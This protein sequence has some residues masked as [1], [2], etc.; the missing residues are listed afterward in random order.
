MTNSHT[1]FH[2]QLDN[3]YFPNWIIITI[4][5]LI[6]AGLQILGSFS[7]LF[8]L[9][10]YLPIGSSSIVTATIRVILM[11]MSLGWIIY[12][13]YQKN[14]FPFEK[15]SIS[16]L[17]IL[18][19]LAMRFIYDAYIGH[20][21]Y[22]E[23]F[24]RSVVRF[25]LYFGFLV[26][27]TIFLVNG[28][29]RS[30]GKKIILYICIL[31]FITTVGLYFFWGYYFCQGITI[32][33][34]VTSYPTIEKYVIL[35]EKMGNDNYFNSFLSA[36]HALETISYA[37]SI[38]FWA[39][40]NKTISIKVFLPL[41]IFFLLPCYASSTRSTL[42]M[43]I[44]SHCLAAVF[45]SYKNSFTFW[46][47]ILLVIVCHLICLF[48]FMG[49]KDTNRT[50]TILGRWTQVVSM[51]SDATILNNN[52]KEIENKKTKIEDK[53]VEI[54][55]KEVEI[56]DK[57]TKIKNDSELSIKINSDTYLIIKNIRF[58][59]WK[60]CLE[61]IYK[62]PI[63]GDGLYIV[64]NLLNRKKDK[65]WNTHPHNVVIQVFMGLG[66]FG[67]TLFLFILG[68]G[69]LDAITCL[70]VTPEMGWLSILFFMVIIRSLLWTDIVRDY[71][72]WFLLI[73]LRAN[74][75]HLYSARHK[76]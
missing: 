48:I 23:S 26:L 15:F 21:I 54:K 38:I 27:P 31:S 19:L 72:L 64:D 8:V 1:L 12:F 39:S 14:Y 20:F 68:R 56:K 55:D 13:I 63:T 75:V 28:I 66:I 36:I 52:D 16:I 24:S 50:M 34:M 3:K 37:V 5:T 49:N 7:S 9:E 10:G 69:I 30:N 22:P 76:K 35:K 51:R 2:D 42:L 61:R 62:S 70:Y 65:N 67:G 53:E 45:S 58:F 18:I 47:K 33:S 74:T 57:E 11:G 6:F 43:I 46:S 25:L 44:I 4:C 32:K 60:H 17:V 71:Q 40:I 59:I 41:Y 29:S 73:A